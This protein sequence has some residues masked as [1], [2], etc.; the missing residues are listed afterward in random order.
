MRLTDGIRLSPDV[1]TREVSG[2]TMLLNLASGTYYGLDP[3]GA[4][5]LSLVQQGKSALKARDVLLELY[6]VEPATLDQDLE[7]LLESLSL[8]GIVTAKL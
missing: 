7:A 6:D 2:E 3:V 4:R 8:N 5:F 1:V